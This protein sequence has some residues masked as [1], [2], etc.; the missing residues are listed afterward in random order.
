MLPDDNDD[1]QLLAGFNERIAKAV[2]ENP[3]YKVLITKQQAYEEFIKCV[4]VQ[5]DGGGGDGVKMSSAEI[6][7]L[8]KYAFQGG[9]IRY[10]N[11]GGAA[12]TPPATVDR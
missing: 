2:D 4:K 11:G 6:R 12:P 7:A 10:N 9:D 5:N 8:M 3:T 1:D